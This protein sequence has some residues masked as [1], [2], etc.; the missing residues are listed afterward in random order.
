MSLWNNRSPLVEPKEAIMDELRMISLNENDPYMDGFITSKF[1]KELLDIYWYLEDLLEKTSN[2]GEV[3]KEW[4]EDR[5]K[6]KMINKL[7]G[8]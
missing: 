8:K 4:F 2:Y 6:Q 1:K 5:E 7:S 3:E